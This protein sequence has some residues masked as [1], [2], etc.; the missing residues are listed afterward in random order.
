MEVSVE[1]I[2]GSDLVRLINT[3]ILLLANL[4]SDVFTKFVCLMFMSSLA[5]LIVKN[6]YPCDG[7]IYLT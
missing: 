3:N 7:F 4:V 1:M 5:L 6:V 2:A